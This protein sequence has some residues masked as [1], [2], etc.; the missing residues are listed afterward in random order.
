[1]AAGGDV[2]VGDPGRKPLP[3]GRLRPIA[4]YTVPDFGDPAPKTAST[5]FAWIRP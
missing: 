2:L 1:V 4:R 5:V 3:L